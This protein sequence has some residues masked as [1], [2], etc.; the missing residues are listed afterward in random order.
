MQAKG[1]VVGRNHGEAAAAAMTTNTTVGDPLG[2]P[3]DCP[4][5]M[6]SKW[7]RLLP[8]VAAGLAPVFGCDAPVVLR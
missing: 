3:G 7:T 8:F 6:T 1:Y 2:A 4:L 5:S